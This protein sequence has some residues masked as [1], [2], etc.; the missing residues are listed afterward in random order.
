MNKVI[1]VWKSGLISR[2]SGCDIFVELN[3]KNLK[4]SVRVLNYE[5]QLNMKNNSYSEFALFIYMEYYLALRF[6]LENI[7][8]QVLLKYQYYFLIYFLFVI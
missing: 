2:D 5:K 8:Y 4:L 3:S 6:M 1:C 7:T